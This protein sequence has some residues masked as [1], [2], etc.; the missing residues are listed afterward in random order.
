MSLHSEGNEQPVPLLRRRY[1]IKGY[2]IR[3][4]KKTVEE[5]VER[6]NRQKSRRK[7]CYYVA[8]VKGEYLYLD[9]CDYGNV[10][11]ICRLTHTGKMDEWK[12]AIFKYSTETYDPHEWMFPGSEHVDG[13][14]EGAMKA[15]LEAY[16][17]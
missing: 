12:F 4:S 1:E 13:T 17:V 10:G 11:R 15:G 7:D 6:F 16:P 3:T 2:S 5:I 9:R 14:I 8:R